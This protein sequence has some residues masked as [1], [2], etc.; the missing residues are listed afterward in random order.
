MNQ[1][2]PLFVFALFACCTGSFLLRAQDDSPPMPDEKPRLNLS[3][4]L[5][6]PKLGGFGGEGADVTWTGKWE[7]AKGTDEGLITITAQ[8]PAEHHIYST[9]T[10]GGLPTRFKLSGP[11]AV[12]VTGAFEPQQDPH[13]RE[14]PELGPVEEHEG[15]VTWTAAIRFPR[16]LNA[17]EVEL[18]IN[19]SGQV[20]KDGEGGNCRPIR[21][22]IPLPFAGYLAPAAQPGEVT[23][24]SSH[25]T[26]QGRLE[27]A[28]VAPGGKA[29]LILRAEPEAG[30][31]LYPAAAQFDE[32]ATGPRPTLLAMSK[33]SGWL[34]SEPA[35][36]NS[37]SL[38]KGPGGFAYYQGPVEWAIT[39]RA[40]QAASG[41][42]TLRGIVGFQL[43]S[44]SA[45]TAPTALSFSVPAKIAG[46]AANGDSRLVT[47]ATGDYAK[48]AET[49]VSVRPTMSNR[50]EWG[51][52][53]PQLGLAILGGLLLNLMPCVLPVIGLKV[54]SFARQA[55][56]SRARV[57]ILN[58][59]YVAG[60][61]LVFLALAT[62]A[63]FLNWGWG[64][65]FTSLEF[66]VTMTALVF[67]MALSFLGVWQLPVPGFATSENAGKLQNQHG[68]TGAFFKGMFTTVLA[69]PCSG[70]FLGAVFGYTL[71]QPPI[72]TY[73]I[74]GAVGLGMGLPY[75]MVG[76]FPALVKFLPKPGEWM[77]TF[78]NVLGFVLLATVVYLMAITGQ[79]YF[80]PTFALL[81]GLWF[82]CWLIG[83]VPEYAGTGKVVATWG[84]AT[85]VVA[86]VA[87]GSFTYLSPVRELYEWKPYS[88]QTLADLQKEGKTVMLDFTADWCATCQWNFRTA[89]NT[90]RVQS[91]VQQNGVAA[92]KAD[93]TDF[94]DEIQ[95]KLRELESNSIPLLAI[96]PADNPE[97]P[98][99]LRDA[100]I[101]SQVL[102]ALEKAGPSRAASNPESS[103]AMRERSALRP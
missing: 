76:L 2:W 74:F 19:V 69:T 83:R 5:G 38:K 70:P 91:V 87:Y 29:R 82:A 73:L 34:W 25:V 86:A 78:E 88:Q 99:I 23:L 55:G 92:V 20:C 41:E 37:P 7:A 67:V 32:K 14:S 42:S 95:Q 15:S 58:V 33:T 51:T 1:R 40:P 46:D 3:R 68:Y 35:V 12:Q 18:T 43:C 31:H 10:K 16:D 72:V 96:F 93:W 59:A 71:T 17:E 103:T 97:E 45:C 94:S 98:I 50:I 24:A 62:A 64:Q 61:M 75:L 49:V 22:K 6:L 56:E 101:E 11:D 54:L 48:A 66:R 90:S 47:F 36:V 79:K 60:L 21:S 80:I 57:L 26:W 13:A 28:N 4:E 44:E 65:Q 8:V 63:A 81:I 89:L 39:L 27:P 100:V 53:W 85:L 52:L 77:E 30:W 9:T 102:A 84:V